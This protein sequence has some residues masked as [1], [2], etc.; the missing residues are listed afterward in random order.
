MIKNVKIIKPNLAYFMSQ[1][2]H[3]I[4]LNLSTD[5]ANTKHK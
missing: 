4:F 5:S 1:K 3:V 2:T